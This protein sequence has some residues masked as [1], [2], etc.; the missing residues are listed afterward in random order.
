MEAC[1]VSTLTCP[2]RA[3]TGL[4]KIEFFLL[5]TNRGHFMNKQYIIHSD[6]T[7]KVRAGLVHPLGRTYIKNNII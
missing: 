1:F 5:L 6:D 3:A 4:P 2:T 7:Q